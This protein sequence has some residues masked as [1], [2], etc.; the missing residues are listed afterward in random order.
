[1]STPSVSRVFLVIIAKYTRGYEIF[2]HFENY[3]SNTDSS[4]TRALI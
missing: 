4:M 3:T 2:K 1:M